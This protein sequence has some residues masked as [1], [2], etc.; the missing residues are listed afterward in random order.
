ML[1]PK[2]GLLDCL[3]VA[4]NNEGI[5]KIISPG[6]EGSFECQASFQIRRMRL[7]KFNQGASWLVVILEELYRDTRYYGK[8]FMEPLKTKTSEKAAQLRTVDF[9]KRMKHIE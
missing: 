8:S 4:Q 5:S 9:F 3:S 7:A 1:D 6:K 2:Y